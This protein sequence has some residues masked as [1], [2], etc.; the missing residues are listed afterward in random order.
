MDITGQNILTQERGN[1]IFNTEVV[2]VAFSSDG[3]WLATVE[4][5]NDSDTSPDL[6]L[7]FWNY[8]DVKQV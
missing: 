3:D 7:K 4:Y 6:R 2:K 1:V 5:R 8:D